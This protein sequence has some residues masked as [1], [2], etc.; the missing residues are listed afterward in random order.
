MEGGFL[1]VRFTSGKAGPRIKKY[2]QTQVWPL[3]FEILQS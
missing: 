3:G 1:E 2:G